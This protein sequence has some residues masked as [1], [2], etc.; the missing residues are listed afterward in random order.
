MTAT[1]KPPGLRVAA[2]TFIVTII[3]VQFELIGFLAAPFDRVFDT[4][5]KF[6][7]RTFARK[8]T[9]ILQIAIAL[10]DGCINSSSV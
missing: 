2:A 7:D 5:V 4:P 10:S 1:R 3:L 9:M 8:P 6:L